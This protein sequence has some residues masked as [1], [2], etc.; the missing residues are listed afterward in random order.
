MDHYS[1]LSENWLPYREPR[2][3]ILI[4]CTS[5]T[6]RTQVYLIKQGYIRNRLLNKDY[7]ITVV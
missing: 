3:V 2:D 4:K 6:Y 7:K 5:C 1:T